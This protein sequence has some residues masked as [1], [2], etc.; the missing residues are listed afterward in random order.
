MGS[1]AFMCTITFCW[2]IKPNLTNGFLPKD[3]VLLEKMFFLMKPSCHILEL[4][5]YWR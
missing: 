2:D 3:G 1:G 4:E 5:A